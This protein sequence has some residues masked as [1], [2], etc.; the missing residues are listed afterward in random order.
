MYPA[1]DATANTVIPLATDYL[2][3]LFLGT[4]FIFGFHVFS[5]LMRGYGNTRLLMRV[6]TVSVLLNVVAD[7]LFIFG[8]G[9]IDGMGIEGA[10]IAT[11]LA[12]GVATVIGLYILFR[13]SFGPDIRL[14]NLVPDVSHVWDI[15]RIGTPSA[16]EESSGALAMLTLTAIIVTFVSPV[17]AAYGLGN[18]IVSLVFL[19]AV[20]LG[21]AT[22]TIVGQNLGAGKV[23]RAEQAVW[24]AAKAGC[25]VMVVVAF[26]ALAF[27]DILVSV[28]LS[29][30]SEYANETLRH[31]SEY[32][33]IRTI[34]F[35]F[36]G[37]FHVLVG[38]YRGPETRKLR[39][40]SRW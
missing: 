24:L 2:R 23:D 32:L 38:A 28:F 33:E 7:P 10:A 34:E 27:S 1:Q 15:V 37:L 25:A 21:R 8:W 4:P 40:C 36:I 14:E 18:R 13:T 39:W 11:V 6:L 20:G 31:A 16:L 30:G 5:A 35:V 19:P 26:V 9:S 3:V 22:N 29:S 17:I 12:R